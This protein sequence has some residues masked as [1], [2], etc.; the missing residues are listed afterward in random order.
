MIDTTKDILFHKSLYYFISSTSLH[1][2]YQLHQIMSSPQQIFGDQASAELARLG[3]TTSD[4]KRK[5]RSVTKNMS[6]ELVDD[7][8][9]EAYEEEKMTDWTMQL[10][11]QR[12][13]EAAV[14][15]KVDAVAPIVEDAVVE[16]K[17]EAVAPIVED[18]AVEI[19]VEAV[20]AM[21]KP[22]RGCNSYIHFSKKNRAIVKA[23]NPE[24]A[25]KDIVSE[26]SKMWKGLDEEAKA[27]YK[28]M[29]AADKLR[30]QTEMESYVPS[31]TTETKKTKKPKTT[32]KK[33]KTKK[34]SCSKRCMARKWN[35]KKGELNGN[36]QCRQFCPS[37]EA[38]Y[39][40]KCQTQSD[41]YEGKSGAA[42]W[43]FCH[44]NG[45]TRADT[46]AKGAKPGLWFGRMDQQEGEFDYPV[47]SFVTDAGQRIVVSAFPDNPTHHVV[48]EWHVKQSANLAH[49]SSLKENWPKKF[50]KIGQL[51][52][53][54]KKSQK[55]AS[56]VVQ[57]AN[58]EKLFAE[59]IDDSDNND[60]DSDDED[61]QEV[62]PMIPCIYSGSVYN[63]NPETF[64]IVSDEG[65]EIGLWEIKSDAADKPEAT[66][67]IKVWL[68]K[69]GWP[70]DDA[71]E[72][73]DAAE[74]SDDSDCE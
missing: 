59:D 53:Q 29:A 70:N 39:C 31:T 16:I 26:L 41:N 64:R 55:K 49:D 57:V 17:V 13:A 3:I 32:T 40:Q 24:M 10:L 34:N 18:A 66:S 74:D 42:L 62:L 12:A 72:V 73:I 33:T 69:Y 48:E 25:P 71:Q 23:A 14:E 43:K 46:K 4:W 6:D 52:K 2:S 15:I 47:A 67:E 60:G 30:Y 50:H 21:P 28:A 11:L 51:S 37:E 54:A 63:V 56:K 20:A 65:Y 36:K 45:I 8:A 9:I 27:P 44:A 1:Q 68:E 61:E 7:G 38:D 58:V 22:K 19:K 35:A 5:Y